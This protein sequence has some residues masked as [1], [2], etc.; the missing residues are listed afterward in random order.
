MNHDAARRSSLARLLQLLESSLVMYIADAGIWSFPGDEEIKLALADL[1]ADHKSLTERTGTL[2]DERGSVPARAAYPIQFT[3][4]HD[5][6]LRSLLPRILAGLRRQA[7]DFEGLAAGVGDGD[8][9]AADLA[10][11]A[12]VSTAQHI[13]VLEQIAARP[14][15]AAS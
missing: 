14:R 4:T 2:L 7:A 5:L 9:T 13:Q 11:E 1:V 3:A 10:R 8:A 12:R 6:D 15:T